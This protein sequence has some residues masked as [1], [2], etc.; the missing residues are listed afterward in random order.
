[1][2]K[3][4]EF[5]RKQTRRQ[6]L[7]SSYDLYRDLTDFSMSDIKKLLEKREV[8]WGSLAIKARGPLA[9]IIYNFLNWN[10]G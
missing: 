1:M 10:L 9:I 7:V 4:L 6:L 5:G 8:W 2:N 3:I